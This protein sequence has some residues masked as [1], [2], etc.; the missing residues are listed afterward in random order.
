MAYFLS[1]LTIRADNSPESMARVAEL[2]LDVSV[3]RLP[4]LFDNEFEFQPGIAPVS[5]Y[6][7]YDDERG[8]FDLS[9]IG[10][11]AD[12]FAW[13]EGQVAAGK[14]RKF[15]AADPTGDLEAC[16]KAVLRQVRDAQTR[17]GLRR[18]FTTDY[19][20]T[21]PAEYAEDG[22]AHCSLYIAV[23]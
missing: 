15:E 8:D 20:S 19:E 7:N 10:V 11:D 18:A 22:Q 13:L 4:L 9:I 12:F 2:W 1:G 3:G 21:V 23:K 6:S 16:T 5:R 17:S 14:Y